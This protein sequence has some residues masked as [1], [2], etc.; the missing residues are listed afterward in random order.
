[1]KAPGSFAWMGSLVLGLLLAG[2]LWAGQPL[3]E[4]TRWNLQ[5]QNGARV[6]HLHAFL[7]SRS[8]AQQWQAQFP[9]APAW[10]ATEV[11]RTLEPSPLLHLSRPLSK[12]QQAWLQQTVNAWL[13]HPWREQRDAELALL[14]SK[15]RSLEAQL[16]VLQIQWDQLDSGF[17][18]VSLEHDVGALMTSVRLQRELQIVS[19]LHAIYG[20]EQG[21]REQ[22]PPPTVVLNALR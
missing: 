17:R 16:Q 15:L 6:E 2:I 10:H 8:W 13:E 20:S 11:T 3:L 18:P 22:A 9:D 1:L 21:Q 12:A 7:S 4:P 5:P 14:A 19:E